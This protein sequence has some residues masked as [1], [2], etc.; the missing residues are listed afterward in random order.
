MQLTEKGRKR[1]LTLMLVQEVSTRSL[2]TA[3]GWKSHTILSRLLRGE[4]HTITPDKAA[5]I[6]LAL[7][8]GMDDLFVPRSSI[9]ARQNVVQRARKSAA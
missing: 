5:R 7:G 4:Q 8:V 6:A 1:L 9:G 3:V 2:A